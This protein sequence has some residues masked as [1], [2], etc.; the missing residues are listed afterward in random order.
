MKNIY[1][2][3]GAIAIAF[4]LSFTS[5]SDYLSVDK[6]FR[7][8]QTEQKI[9][10]DDLY[11]LQ[12]L[13]YCYCRLLGD[14]IEIGHTRFAPQNFADDQVFSETYGRYKAYKLGEIGYGY[15]YSGYYQNTWKWSYAAILQASILINNVDINKD[16]TQEEIQDVK[17]Q[18]RFLRAYFYW[19]LLRRFGPIPLM[20]TE[21]V[22]YAKTYDE[23]SY[24]RNTYD[25][26]VDFIAS[27]MAQAAKE[28]REKRD[29]LNLARPTRGAALAVRAKVYLYGASP[30]AN[31]NTEMADFVDKTGRILIP[32]EYDESKWAK[33]AAAARDVIE[34]GWYKLF[35]LPRRD[36]SSDIANPV[37]VKPPYNEKFSDKNFPEGWADIDPF[38][39]YRTLFNGEVYLYNNPEIIFGRVTNDAAYDKDYL[40]DACDVADMAKHQMPQSIGGWNI[41]S[42]TM[43]QCD[44]YDMAD[45]KPYDRETGLTG[46]TN[47]TNKD[48]HPYDNLENNVWLGYANRE[49][50]FYASVG[51]NG[52]TWYCQS[53]TATGSTEIVNKQV[54]YY[55]GD[56]DGRSNGTERWLVTGIGIKKYINPADCDKYSGSIVK[57][58]EPALRYADI[59]VSYAE[60]L[61]NLTTTYEIPSWDGSKTYTI[62]RD[63]EEMRR[64]IKP[65]RMRA[66]VPDYEDDVYAD[67]DAFFEKIV[68]ERQIEFFNESQRYY[69]V[70]RWKIAPEHEGAQIYGCN[71]MMDKTHREAFYTP[72]R[73]TG[74]Q[75]AFSRKQYFWPMNYDELQRNKNMT[76]APGWQDYD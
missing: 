40:V 14:N 36:K 2:L 75:T 17:G 28:L 59:L 11:T 76:Q 52:A 69:D 35:T 54:W 51:Y 25:E 68:H 67:R 41:H 19:I 50:R 55:R 62:S 7:D 73:V 22:D 29:N 15:G 34:G 3:L 60:A 20:P 72:V 57:K 9:F 4:Q 49:P 45:G 16:F 32:Q 31:G 38:D 18:A 70:R 56:T 61:N 44:A 23:L 12:W 46:F 6:H 37:T 53:A 42:M 13:S 48:L 33:A 63:V 58:I 1:I 26:C 10:E 8:V 5:C 66:G 47:S 64:G 24:P 21:G 43:K 27:E 71:I 74:I 39:S 65:V 30:L